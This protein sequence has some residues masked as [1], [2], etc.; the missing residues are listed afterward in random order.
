M[1]DHVADDDFVALALD[2]LEPADR[3]RLSAHLAACGSCRA[4]YAEVEESVLGAMAAA[5]S[6]APPPGFSG[7]VLTAMG[8]APAEGGMPLAAEAPVPVP[9]PV[10]VPA[11]L[12]GRRPAWRST[13]ARVAVVAAALVLGAVLGIAGTLALASRPAEPVRPA[14]TDPTSAAALVTRTGDTVGTAGVAVLA[15]REY[16]VVTVTR[17]RPGMAYECIAIGKDGQRTSAGTWTLDEH[18]GGTSASGT[19]IVAVPPGGVEQVELVTA[20]GT[21]W[22]RAEL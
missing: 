22:S 19:W 8:L 2:E 10:T 17:G 5:P 3:A 18:Y 15:G 6:I 13:A 14:P 9:V 12:Q 1:T 21:V 16:L 7:R 11:Q 4:E 20:S